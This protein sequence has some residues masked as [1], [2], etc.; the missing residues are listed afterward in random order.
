MDTR[1]LATP[2]GRGLGGTLTD[3]AVLPTA[4][5]QKAWIAHRNEVS[6]NPRGVKEK[7]DFS[8]DVCQSFAG[9]KIV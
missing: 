1:W 3:Q 4:G 2:S 8:I 9:G 5:R 6:P 7:L